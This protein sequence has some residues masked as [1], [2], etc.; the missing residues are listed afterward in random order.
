[1]KGRLVLAALG[2]GIL[3]IAAPVSAQAKVE[4]GVNVGYTASEGVS[5]D[6]VRL[7]QQYNTLTPVSGGSF[8]FTFGVFFT[9]HAEAEFLWARQSS[10]LDAEGAGQALP[11]SEL[12]LYNYM[13][14]FVYNWGAHDAKM[15]PYILA[16]VG[17]TQYSFGANLLPA[18]TGQIAG[19]TRFSTDIGGGLKFNFSPNVGAKVGL[20]YTPTYIAS[21]SAGVWCDPFY[22]CWPIAN[23]HYANQFDT[24]VGVTVRFD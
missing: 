1:M 19:E 24:S 18:A 11:L 6:Q 22:G 17:A 4:V 13:G 7:G 5:T 15:R 12:T 2:F 3:A 9:E 8:G 16:G 21:T 14:N 23:A 20:R 10:R